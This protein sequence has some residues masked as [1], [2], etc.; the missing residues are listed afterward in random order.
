MRPKELLATRRAL[1]A[2]AHTY[3]DAYLADHPAADPWV[4]FFA[5]LRGLQD[6]VRQALDSLTPAV[7]LTLSDTGRHLVAA[8]RHAHK[9]RARSK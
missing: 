3:S 2:V 1:E 5:V 8:P 4:V 6:G 9:F 7:Q